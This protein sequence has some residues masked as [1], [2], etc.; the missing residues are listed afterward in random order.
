MFVSL[1]RYLIQC[2]IW[3]PCKHGKYTGV[4][5]KNVLFSK[6]KRIERVRPLFLFSSELVQPESV[7][8]KVNA[9]KSDSPGSDLAVQRL[10]QTG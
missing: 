7:L 5:D 3:R 6:H 9:H 4:I 10:P 2:L 1:R 8:S